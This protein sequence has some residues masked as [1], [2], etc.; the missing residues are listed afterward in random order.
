MIVFGRA[1]LEITG[2]AHHVLPRHDIHVPHVNV[3]GGKEVFKG[4]GSFTVAVGRV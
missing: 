4:V 3:I 2:E 1:R